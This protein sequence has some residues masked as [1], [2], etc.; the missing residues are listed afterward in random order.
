MAE[1]KG[2]DDRAMSEILA[3]IRKIVTSEERARRAADEGREGEGEFVLEL[4]ESMRA[5]PAAAA[6]APPE[7]VFTPV[8]T[9]SPARVA[10]IEE[11]V[12]RVIREE[13][14]GP[15]GLEISRKVKA[16]IRNEVRRTIEDD[17][18]LI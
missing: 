14:K 10:E 16:S 15:I 18:P 4:T 7:P 13:L 2:G 5:A 17:G 9:L 6:S 11:I 1:E 3:S 12:R 8:S